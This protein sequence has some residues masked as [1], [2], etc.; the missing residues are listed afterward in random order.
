MAHAAQLL[1]VADDNAD[2]RWLVRAAL[3]DRFAEIIEAEDGR[4]LFWEL[5]KCTKT[6]SASE[7]VVVTDIRMPVY[8]GLDVLAIYDELDFR[9]PTV[10]ITSF[11][12]KEVTAAVDRAGAR[13]LAKPFATSE[14]RKAVDAC[15][16]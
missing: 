2:M 10:V 14:L 16:Q 8:S 12:S 9:P 15:R 7:V 4:R 13:L 1:I 6:R 5:V 11:P 3:R